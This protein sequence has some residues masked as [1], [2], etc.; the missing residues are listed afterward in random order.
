VTGATD[1]PITTIQS[2]NLL[3]WSIARAPSNTQTAK[4]G[5]GFLGGLGLGGPRHQCQRRAASLR[6]LGTK[7]PTDARKFN[8]PPSR[9]RRDAMFMSG[10]KVI[11]FAAKGALP[12]PICASLRRRRPLRCTFTY[13]ETKAALDT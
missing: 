2:S 7:A 11:Y 5:E 3:C 10:P 6:S 1:M 13:I 4:C 9:R 12:L 8:S